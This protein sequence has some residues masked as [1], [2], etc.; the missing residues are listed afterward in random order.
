M[1]FE[2]WD[3]VYLYFEVESQEQVDEL[4]LVIYAEEREQQQQILFASCSREEIKFCIELQDVDQ[5]KEFVGI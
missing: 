3:L 5:F 1:T 2:L 4:D